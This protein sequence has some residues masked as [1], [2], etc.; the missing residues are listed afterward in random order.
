MNLLGSFDMFVAICDVVK[1]IWGEGGGKKEFRGRAKKFLGAQNF[2][3][4]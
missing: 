3:E 2:L 4:V 1:K